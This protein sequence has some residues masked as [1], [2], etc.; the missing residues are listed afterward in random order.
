M[1]RMVTGET[2]HSSRCSPHWPVARAFDH[3]AILTQCLAV[4]SDHLIP[5]IRSTVVRPFDPEPPGSKTHVD[6]SRLVPVSSRIHDCPRV[7]RKPQLRGRGLVLV[8]SDP[9]K[10]GGNFNVAFAGFV[11]LHVTTGRA[12]QKCGQQKPPHPASLHD[13]SPV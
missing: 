9:S 6:F 10:R 1:V 5:G 3:A 13:L 2:F 4:E 7:S 8:D 11:N 12:N